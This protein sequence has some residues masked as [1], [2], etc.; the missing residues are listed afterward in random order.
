MTHLVFQA[1]PPT[2]ISSA[3]HPGSWRANDPPRALPPARIPRVLS[4]RPPLDERRCPLLPP[5][6]RAWQA[7]ASWD[8]RAPLCLER[9]P[10]TAQLPGRGIRWGAPHVIPEGLRWSLEPRILPRPCAWGSPGPASNG[11][12]AGRHPHLKD[13]TLVVS[14]GLPQGTDPLPQLGRIIPG[15]LLTS[16]TGADDQHGIPC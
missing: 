6:G 3:Q 13:F 7:T 2:P 8:L 5:R 14:G 4:T 9:G 10:R 12:Q 1:S 16:Q 15:L 11:V